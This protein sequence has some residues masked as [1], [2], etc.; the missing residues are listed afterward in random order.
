MDSGVRDIHLGCFLLETDTMHRLAVIGIL[1]ILERT[2]TWYSWTS[3]DGEQSFS[4]ISKLGIHFP[5]SP[6][7]TQHVDAA[8][9]SSVQKSI[10]VASMKREHTEWINDAF[11]DWEI[12]TYVANDKTA[13]YTVLRNEG[14]EAS[15]YLTYIINNYYNLPDYM[16][17][18]PQSIYMSSS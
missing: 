8:V 6:N 15:T 17:A 1:L 3:S 5:W 12:N 9:G 2:A 16:Y 14:H 4:A 13:N 10:I 18:L 11:P 7:A